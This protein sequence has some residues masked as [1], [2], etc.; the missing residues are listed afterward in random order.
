MDILLILLFIIIIASLLN[1]LEKAA[2]EKQDKIINDFY[3]EF[4]EID[5]NCPPHKWTYH[6]KTNRLTCTL[7]NY[8]AGSG[9][10]ESGDKPY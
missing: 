1:A 5:K 7:C 3:K 6:P 4:H 9:S 10:Q 2:K 8:E